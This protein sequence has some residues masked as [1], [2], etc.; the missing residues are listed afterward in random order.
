MDKP[1]TRR[2]YYDFKCR[3][4]T[5]TVAD[6]GNNCHTGNPYA[7]IRETRCNGQEDTHQ[8]GIAECYDGVWKWD[9]ENFSDYDGTADDILLFLTENGLPEIALHD[10]E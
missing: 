4:E 2:V 3:G 8:F 5:Y 9:E 10:T 1:Y 6:Y 7:E